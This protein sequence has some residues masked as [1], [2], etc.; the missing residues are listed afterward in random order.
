[1]YTIYINKIIDMSIL[2]PR[3]KI[4]L[5]GEPLLKFAICKMLIVSVSMY[6]R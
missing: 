1:M 3:E 4:G 6:L 2:R 5:C